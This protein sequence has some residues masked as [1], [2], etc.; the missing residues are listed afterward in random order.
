MRIRWILAAALP[1]LLLLGGCVTTPAPAYA[2][3]ND[4]GVVLRGQPGAK[5]GVDTFQAAPDVAN[6]RLSLR[7][8][9]MTGGSDGTYATYLQQALEAELRNANRYDH[10]STTRV[11]A[12]LLA[13]KLD[14]SGARTGKASIRARFVVT[15]DGVV[16]Y[17]HPLQ[18]DHQWESSFIG[19]LAV[20]TA[21]ENYVATVQK[22]IGLLVADPGFTEATR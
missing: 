18:A 21:M 16:A 15:R 12:V 20:P 5:L 19:A 6:S 22:L 13:N 9:G 7:G 2:P 11:S 1:A 4:T 10:A 8:N 17:D 3:G 14:A